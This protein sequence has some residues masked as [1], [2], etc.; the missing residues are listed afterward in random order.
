LPV[1]GRSLLSN[2]GTRKLS[3]VIWGDGAVG[4][5]MAVAL[6]SSRRVVLVGP[7]G[8]GRGPAR[9]ESFGAYPGTEEVLRSEPDDHPRGDAC[10]VAVKS[11][12]LR[13]VSRSAEASSDADCICLSNGM[14]LETEWGSG[15]ADRVEPALLTA[16]FRLLSPSTV[17]TTRGT[18][19]VGSGG[20][21]E[22]LLSGTAIPV[23]PTTELEA[24]RW[25]KW[26]ANSVINPL[27]AITGLPN[28]RLLDAGLAPLIDRLAAE[29]A[30]IVPTEMREAAV[31]CSARMLTFLLE[32]SPN[33]CSM[34]QD[35][36]AGRKSEIGNL[37]G[38]CG[39]LEPGRCPSAEL[40]T[41]LVHARETA[42]LGN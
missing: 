25:G 26:L 11:Y 28:D 31:A 10:I 34:L 27:G 13:E 14:G 41:L 35:L 2:S 6:S 8:S 9:L 36:E 32:S 15:W 5:G 24:A 4:T 1:Q 37:T 29:M 40:L 19:I 21:A 12:D 20:S 38:L 3:V 30:A 23:E 18:I 33:M 16:G 22:A 42:A 7:P 17:N 39:V